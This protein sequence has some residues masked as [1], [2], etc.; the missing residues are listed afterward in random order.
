MGIGCALL[1]KR[2]RPACP[3]TRVPDKPSRFQARFSASAGFPVGRLRCLRAGRPSGSRI[4]QKEKVAGQELVGENKRYGIRVCPGV[5][6]P[7]LPLQPSIS[8]CRP[9]LPFGYAFCR[10]FFMHYIFAV[11]GV[12]HGR[13][14]GNMVGVCMRIYH[15]RESEPALF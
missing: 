2:R 14:C 12:H 1:L 13:A 5:S 10:G 9:L 6:I 8:E 15:M 7:R 3:G 11:S 4:V